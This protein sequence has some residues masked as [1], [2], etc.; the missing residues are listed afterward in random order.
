M[1]K[2][3]QSPREPSLSTVAI[4]TFSLNQTHLEEFSVQ[5]F[6]SLLQNKLVR[7]WNISEEPNLYGAL[8]NKGIL[9]NILIICKNDTWMNNTEKGEY[10]L[11][12]T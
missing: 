7:K 11:Q 6:S 8:K 10:K 5:N 9:K 12:G 1:R 3:Y 4:V 2:F